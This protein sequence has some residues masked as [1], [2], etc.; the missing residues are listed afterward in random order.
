VNALK[1]H[2]KVLEIR[3]KQAADFK[4]FLYVIDDC[5]F[6][7]E[8][9]GFKDQSLTIRLHASEADRKAR[10]DAW[11]DDVNHISEI[12][13]DQVEPSEWGLVINTGI[14]SKHQTFN[15]A[16]NKILGRVDL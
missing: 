7:N 3:A 5:R 10:C 15:I 1:E 14:I 2:I 9:Y 11:R 4:Q 13:L 12:D 16:M 8:F 6:Q